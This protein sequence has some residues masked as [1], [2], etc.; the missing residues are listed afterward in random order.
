MS[1]NYQTDKLKRGR[2]TMLKR[3]AILGLIAA[4]AAVAAPIYADTVLQGAVRMIPTADQPSLSSVGC[5]YYSIGGNGSPS[6]PTINANTPTC[7]ND[8]CIRTFVTAAI[9]GG[10]GFGGY[11]CNQES[12]GVYGPPAAEPSDMTYYNLIDAEVGAGTPNHIAYYAV[13]GQLANNNTTGNAGDARAL[14]CAG[15]VAQNCFTAGDPT[16]ADA[17]PLQS[18]FAT[19]GSTPHQIRSI[20][21]LSP[22][23]TP[24]VSS[25]GQGGCAGNEVRVTWDDPI[26]ATQSMKNGVPSPVQ[27]VNLYVNPASCGAGPSGNDA[28]WVSVGQFS[29]TAGAA[30]TCA[31]IPASSSGWFALTVRLKG[32]TSAPTTIETGRVGATGFVGANSQCVGAVGTVSR[33]VSLAARYAGRGTVNVNFTSGTE[34]GVQG[35]YITRATSP[36]GPYTRVSDQISA[37]G[38]NSRYTFADHIR[39]NLGRLVYYQVEIVNNDGTIEHSGSTSVT[40]PGP[41]MKKLG[42]E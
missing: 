24:R 21:G 18:T 3:F 4:L 23:P 9:F 26:D 19:F 15:T 11:N 7:I 25:P 42:G 36:T 6:V 27:G 17:T 16:N 22:V 39:T 38:D 10:A 29:A 13:Q 20:G 35:F 14:N 8:R 2:M 30:G 33:I 34:G 1:R 41:K 5:R 28:G 31:A 32:P 12:T 37:T 40:T